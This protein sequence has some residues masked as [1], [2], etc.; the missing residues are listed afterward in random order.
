M[1]KPP[2]RIQYKMFLGGLLL[3]ASLISLTLS[4]IQTRLSG[5]DSY[6]FLAPNL[7]LA[8]IPLIAALAA[9]WSARNRITFFLILPIFAL[10]WFIFFPNAPYL[11]TDF[12]HLASTNS[13]SPLWFDVILLIWFAWTGLLLGV[14]SLYLMQEIVSRSLNATAGWIFAIGATTLSSFGVYL[15]RFLRWN[16]ID[17]LQD[18]L[19]IAKDMYGIIRHPISNLP[20]YFFTILFTLLFLFIYLAIH[21]FAHDIRHR[22]ER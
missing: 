15:G 2:Y 6:T 19:L 13:S 7:A 17:I 5:T 1:K 16:S 3:L 12:Q 22:D 10:I 8:W 14:T 4:E 11:L 18:P 20:T 21:L 9:Y